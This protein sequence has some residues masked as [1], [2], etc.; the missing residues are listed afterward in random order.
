MA[1]NLGGRKLIMLISLI[2]FVGFIFRFWKISSYPVHLSMDEVAIGYNAY[3]ILKTA[4]DEHGERLPLAFKSVGDY[5]PPVNIYL[6]VPSIALFGKTELAV[7]LP[8]ALLGSLTAVVLILF[9]RELRFSWVASLFSGFWLAVLPWH[10]HFSRGS[11]EAITGLFFLL[12]GSWLSLVWWRNKKLLFLL[13]AG[14]SLSLAVWSYHAERLFV[15]LLAVFFIFLFKE[16]IKLTKEIRRQLFW[17]LLV[18]FIFAVPFVKLTFFTPAIKTRAA[19]TSI[20]RDPM[21]LGKLNN[22]NYSSLGEAIFE[23][24][25]FEIFRFWTGKYLNYYNPKFWFWKGMQFTPPSYPDLGLLYFVDVP[26]FLLGL[27]FLAKTKNNKLRS[28]S[29]FWFFTGPLSASLTMNEQHPLRALVWLPF[30]AVTVTAGVEL[31]R[32]K[33]PELGV[34]LLPLYFIA[35]ILSIGYFYDIYTNHFPRF[36]SEFWQYGY[37][38]ISVWS[39]E[40]R[41]EYKEI[42]ISDTFGSVALNTGVPPLYVLFYCDFDPEEVQA[43]KSTDNIIF[44]RPYWIKDYNLEDTLF[45]S[46]PWDFSPGPE[47][48][49]EQIIKRI[50]FLNGKPAFYFVKTN[51]DEF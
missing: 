47:L 31:I 27:Y 26:L 6:T 49:E 14:I 19:S 24:D 42:R 50:Y 43:K 1:R 18:V 32:E 36:F 30:F 28:V 4:K 8:V 7:R 13:L 34:R 29:F 2:F 40:H 9:M 45:I 33:F 37:K 22:G 3:S 25:A 15:P 51:T 11:F 44:G 20:M 17:L 38:E 12:A 35:L 10:V 5:K 16:K 46:N 39:C 41:A 21:L 48:K 23:N